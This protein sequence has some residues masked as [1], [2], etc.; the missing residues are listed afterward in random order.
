M[1]PRYCVFGDAV[2]IASR[3]ESSGKPNAIHISKNVEN[4]LSPSGDYQ[5]KYRGEIVLKGRGKLPTYW[6]LGRNGSL[7]EPLNSPENNK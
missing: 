3:M 7:D 6:L 1:M 5:I 2:N 4:K